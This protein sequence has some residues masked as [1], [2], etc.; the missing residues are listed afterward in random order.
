[1]ARFITILFILISS[2]S[3]YSQSPSDLIDPQSFNHKLFEKTLHSKINAYRKQNGLRPLIHNSIIYKVANDQNIYLKTKKEITHTQP[4]SGKHTV[5]DRL[6][7]HLKV[8]RYSVA[9]NI[10][11]TFVLKPTLNYLRNGSTKSSVAKTYD[12]AAD[13]MLN[14]WIQSEFHNTNILNKEF[15]LSGIAS[16]FNPKNMSLTAVHVFAKIG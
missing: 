5:Q 15:Q 16:Y 6:A 4:V 10:A 2:V 12:E 11:R 9:E 13:Y 3:V 7:Y 8:S 1:M 14:A